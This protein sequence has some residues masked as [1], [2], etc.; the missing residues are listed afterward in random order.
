MIGVQAF[1]WSFN[2]AE[3]GWVGKKSHISHDAIYVT[4]SRHGTKYQSMLFDMIH[5]KSNAFPTF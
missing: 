2:M 3:G 5:M 4:L 1:V